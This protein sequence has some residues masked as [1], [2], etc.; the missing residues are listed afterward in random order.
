MTG[1]GKQASY[2]VRTGRARSSKANKL[3]IHPMLAGT[4]R[5]VTEQSLLYLRV[6]VYAP[7]AIRTEHPSPLR[8]H[9]DALCYSTKYEYTE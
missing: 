3:G 8:R 6:R 5:S 2:R 9:R 1:Y 7:C 4:L